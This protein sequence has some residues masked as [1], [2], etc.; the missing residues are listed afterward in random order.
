MMLDQVQIAVTCDDGTTV[1]MSIVTNDGHNIVVEP[2][3][4]YVNSIVAQSATTWRG[5]KPVSWEFV[6]ERD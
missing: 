2:T 1:R 4:E 3:E 6:D 5:K